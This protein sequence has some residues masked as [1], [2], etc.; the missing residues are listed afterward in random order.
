MRWA[1]GDPKD[2]LDLPD[3]PDMLEL[4][5]SKENGVKRGLEEKRGSE[6]WMDSLG[7]ER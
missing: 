5:A 1:C 7:T 4:L 3:L 2:C 6:A